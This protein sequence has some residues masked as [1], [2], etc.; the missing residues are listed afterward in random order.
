MSSEALTDHLI[1]VKLVSP[2][3]NNATLTL[4]S[5]INCNANPFCIGRG[6]FMR[7]IARCD[8]SRQEVYEYH[9]SRR[10]D[11]NARSR[12][13]CRVNSKMLRI[14]DGIGKREERGEKSRE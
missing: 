2:L 6:R 3:L 8:L 5:A 11:L 12:P 1:T 9:V 4:S 14:G 13:L 10:V 7:E